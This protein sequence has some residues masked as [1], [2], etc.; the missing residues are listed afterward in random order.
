MHLRDVHPTEMARQMTLIEFDIFKK[1]SAFECVG[2]KWL[3]SNK[4]ELAPNIMVSSLLLSLSP[5][6]FD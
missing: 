6:L 3:K 1:I 5:S 4:R 2:G